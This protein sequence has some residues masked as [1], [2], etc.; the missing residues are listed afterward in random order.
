MIDLTPMKALELLREVVAEYGEDYVYTNPYGAKGGETDDF[1]EPVSCFYVHSDKPGCIAGHALHRAGLTLERL[2]YWES[3]AVDFIDDVP[4]ATGGLMRE[5]QFSQDH[6][7]TW[8][9]ALAAAEEYYRDNFDGSE[10]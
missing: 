6:G 9:Q 8:G 2:T 1:G 3:S 10:D 5:A 4:E 7:G